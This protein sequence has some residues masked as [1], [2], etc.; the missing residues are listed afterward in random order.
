MPNTSRLLFTLTPLII[1]CGLIIGVVYTWTKPYIAEQQRMAVEAIYLDTLQLKPSADIQLDS[2]RTTDDAALL[3]LR[4]PQSIYVA[5]KNSRIVGVVLPLTAREGYA[6]DIDLLLGIDSDGKVTSARVLSQ[7]E[8]RDLG[9]KIEP[10]KSD[11]LKQ[12]RGATFDEGQK[13]QWQLRSEGGDF[14]GITGATVT[15][16]AVIKAVQQGLAY[17]AQHRN[18]LLGG[19]GDE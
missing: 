13:H 14:D 15:S 16:R 18:E 7:R 1:A 17:F 10:N 2:T 8:T 11:W 5:H 6:G 9:D 19:A 4:T 3:G 12:F